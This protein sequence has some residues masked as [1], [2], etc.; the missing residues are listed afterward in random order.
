MSK[1]FLK[2]LREKT[3]VRL[4]LGFPL[5]SLLLSFLMF[6]DPNLGKYLWLQH[7]KESVRQEVAEKINRGLEREKLVLFKLRFE[8]VKT[9]LRWLSSHEFE[10]NHELYDV[11]EAAVDE[12]TV[13]L[14]CW[15]DHEETRLKREID[16]V[17]FQSLGRK[18]EAWAKQDEFSPASRYWPLLPRLCL[19]PRKPQLIAFI[20]LLPCP[21][22]FCLSLQ[23]PKPPPRL[24]EV[25]PPFAA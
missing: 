7:Q 8:E 4:Y 15:A 20:Y 12:G 1:G 6:L 11:V 3:L 23:P 2:R 16:Q 21:D 22:Y 18:K 24:L 25:L 17:I 9:K 19:R 10:F 13:F 14:W 5:L